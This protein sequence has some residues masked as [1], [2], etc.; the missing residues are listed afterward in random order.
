MQALKPQSRTI[1]IPARSLHR[2]E[3]GYGQLV[4]CLKGVA[5]ITQAN[6][7]RDIILSEGESFV[8]DRPGVSVVYALKDAA[9]I[10][11]IAQPAVRRPREMER[12]YAA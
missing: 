6:D 11:G 4:T 1:A 8:L 2:I 7:A 5:W 3:G 10:V 9:I 12:A